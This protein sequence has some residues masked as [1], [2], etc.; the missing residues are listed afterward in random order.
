MRKSLALVTVLLAVS[1][2]A[3]APPGVQRVLSN[4]VNGERTAAARYEA[5]AAQADTEGY[6]GVACL[7]RAQAKAERIHLQ[8]FVALMNERGIPVPPEATPKINVEATDRN[9]QNAISAEQA[10]RDS[11]YLY[12]ISTC[13]DARDEKVAKVFDV[14]RDSETEHANLCAGALRNMNGLKEAKAFYVCPICGYTTDVRLSMC[15]SCARSGSL[16][17]ID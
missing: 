5:Y 13:N 8:R 14:T 4:A 10:E 6:A 15:P 1:A 7:F 12:A 9:L 16:D 17:R 2:F 3:G 11:T